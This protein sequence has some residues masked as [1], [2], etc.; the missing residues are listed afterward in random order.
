MPVDVA[1]T[2]CSVLEMELRI[3]F[4][5][6][7]VTVTERPLLF[8][9]AGVDVDGER[10]RGIASE[11]V[12]PQ[13]FLKGVD[14]ETALEA[15]LSV[16]DAARR[17]ARV[18]D[19]AGGVFDL[20]HRLYRRQAAWGEE[21]DH[22]PLLWSFGV[23]LIERAAIDA[24]CR[25]G[26]TTFSD[27]VRENTLGIDLGAIYDELAGTEPAA[28]L[29]ER[30]SQSVAVRHTVGHGDALTGGAG[31]DDGLPG[32]LREYVRTDGVSHFKVK[33]GGDVERDIQRLADVAV[34]VESEP[35]TDPVYTVDANEQYPDVAELRRFWEGVT[36]RPALSGI[37]DHLVAIE[38]PLPREAAF[39]ETTREA[40]AA[41]DG[42]PVIVDESDGRIDSLSR[43]LS[44]GYA[45]TSH[46]NCKGVFKGVANACLLERRRREGE[47]VFLTGEDLSTVGPVGLQQDLAVVATLGLD[48]AER[49][50]HHYFRG[51]DG[52]PGTVGEQVLDAHPDLY[53]RHPDGFATLAVEDGRVSTE[54]VLSAPFGAG[55]GIPTDPSP[56]GFVPA[57]EWSFDAGG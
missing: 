40:L 57:A 54:S 36:G 56:M 27:A 42:P 25:A 43:A 29:P 28:L 6:G 19:P 41:W 4:E 32:T 44:C 39:S 31:P 46:K 47:A 8:L 7:D 21:S 30:P 24:W 35:G 37:A 11:T 53:R 12:A 38:Q 10:Q 51:L 50:G 52:F 16:V 34:V 18:L 5:Y 23:S 14:Y 49:N 33:L 13:W 1:A 55:T 9:E 17:H 3:P 22:P 2:D 48:H 45:G 26:E 15:M 20:W